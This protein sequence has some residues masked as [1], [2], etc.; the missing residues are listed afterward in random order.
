[1]ADMDRRS[2][3][4][5][6]GLATA[7]LTTGAASACS[8]L[9]VSVTELPARFFAKVAVGRLV[10][11]KELLSASATLSLI[12]SEGAQL[13]EGP[14][15]VAEAVHRLLNIDGFSMIGD[16]K[17]SAMGGLYWITMGPWV[18][19][20]MVKGSAPQLE[21]GNCDDNLSNSLFNVFVNFGPPQII[22]TIL[23]LENR[24]FSGKMAEDYS[25]PPAIKR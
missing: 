20:D 24:R 23:L 6:A 5:T 8:P 16:T 22:K 18:C 2:L 21:F 14:R 1:M 17:T 9:D 25:V 13:F 15:D 10:E 4:L 12:T 11:A 3:I 19:S 7:A